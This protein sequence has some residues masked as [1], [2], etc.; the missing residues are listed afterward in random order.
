MFHA[1]FQGSSND[2]LC[3]Q[4]PFWA[5]HFKMHAVAKFRKCPFNASIIETPPQL[6]LL[7]SVASEGPTANSGRVFKSQQFLP[8]VGSGTGLLHAA[9]D[10]QAGR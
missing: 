7:R 5:E 9:S 2:A 10:G 8:S 4:I 3:Q 1:N 6:S